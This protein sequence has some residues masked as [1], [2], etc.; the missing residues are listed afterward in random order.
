MS[1][2]EVLDHRLMFHKR[3]QNYRIIF[4]HVFILLRSR[5]LTVIRAFLE[6]ISF[7][8]TNIASQILGRRRLFGTFPGFGAFLIGLL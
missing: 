1:F 2:I 8:R 3:A 4:S 6:I 7:H 5:T